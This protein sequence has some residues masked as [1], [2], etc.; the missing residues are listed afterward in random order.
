VRPGL[1]GFQFVFRATLPAQSHADIQ[2][3]HP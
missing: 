1:F 3:P 2:H